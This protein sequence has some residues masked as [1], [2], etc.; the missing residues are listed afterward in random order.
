MLSANFAFV[1][2][3]VIENSNLPK[4]FENYDAMGTIAVAAET[5]R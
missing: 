4:K 1:Q 2:C 3:F 5:G